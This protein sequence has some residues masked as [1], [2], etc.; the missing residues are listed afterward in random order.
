MR[1]LLLLPVFLALPAL[2]ACQFGP[3]YNGPPPPM[4]T[5]GSPCGYHAIDAG[6]C[7]RMG[8]KVPAGDNY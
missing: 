8:Y 6:I 5:T 2:S 4:K 3:F 1:R 7:P